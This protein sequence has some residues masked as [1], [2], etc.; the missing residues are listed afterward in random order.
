MKH[1]FPIMLLSLFLATGPPSAACGAVASDDDE[2]RLWQLSEVEE[3]ALDSSGCLYRNTEIEAY[4]DVVVRKLLPPE[5][6]GAMPIRVNI[7]RNPRFN[8]FSFANGR[9]YIHS[10]ML[11]AM[12]N[13]A[14]LAALLGHESSH[15]L[16]R[17]MLKELR[18]AKSTTAFSATLGA[19]TGNVILPI[20]QLGA[21]AA[22][23][24]YSR[25][26]E[27]EADTEGLRMM[28]AAGYDPGEA[29]KLFVILRNEVREEQVKEPYFF[30]SHPQLQERIDHYE[31]LLHSVYAGKHGGTT[32]AGPFLRTISPLLLDNA[33][34]KL[35]AGR[36]EAARKAI[37]RYLA[38]MGDNARAYL[39][40]GETYRQG[41]IKEEFVKAR[42][43]Y[44]KSALLD[45]SLPDP[46]RFL[47]LMA[48]K[49]NDREQAKASL[50]RYLILSP[51]A[52]DR[53]YIEEMLKSLR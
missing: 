29:P 38:A 3:T 20:G 13:E 6:L 40:L 39:L 26:L 36:F 14:Q 2:T 31:R 30:G 8:A 4:L 48:F 41:G 1:I 18:D 47:G 42:E 15:V 9:I 7:I 33:D 11:A 32:N 12:E 10:G 19:L 17:H 21:L 52:P 53:A 22:I 5:R 49:Q 25:E 23:S 37:E 50:E 51:Q 45:P 27:T 34:S 44:L 28:V 46:H 24:G 16:G 35:K 43:C